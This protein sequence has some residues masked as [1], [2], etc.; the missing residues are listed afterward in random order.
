MAVI[1]RTGCGIRLPQLTDISPWVWSHVK[2]LW[3]DSQFASGRE[4]ESTEMMAISPYSVK[5][6]FDWNDNF[7]FEC[8]GFDWNDGHFAFE[9]QTEFWLKR[10][11]F[12]LWVSEFWLK[13]QWFR[14]AVSLRV[15]TL[16]TVIVYDDSRSLLRA[17]LLSCRLGKTTSKPKLLFQCVLPVDKLL[18]LLGWGDGN[19]R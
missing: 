3:N 9:C 1:L 19:G 18:E 13:W 11:W 5:Q 10:K 7:T 15:L 16:L 6:S 14:V 2:G 8:Q 4:K 12:H 17:S